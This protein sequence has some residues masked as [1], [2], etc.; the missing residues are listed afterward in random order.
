VIESLC[1]VI[2][3]YD[4]ERVQTLTAFAC[5]LPHKQEQIGCLKMAER[6]L[7]IMFLC[8]NRRSSIVL[9]LPNAALRRLAHCFHGIM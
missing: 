3:N 5:R 6:V 8:Y 1:C 9:H 7:L 2:F 4:T